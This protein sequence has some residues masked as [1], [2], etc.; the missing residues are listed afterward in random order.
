MTTEISTIQERDAEL[1]NT[2][3]DPAKI[4]IIKSMFAKNCTNDEFAV[5]LELARRYQLDPFSKQIWA[6]KYNG[7]AAQIFT[8]RDGFLSIAHRSGVFDGMESGVDVD[9]TGETIGWAKVYRK[10]MTH[11]FSITVSLKEYDTGKSLWR[12]KPRTMIQKV[13]ESQCLRRAFSISGLYDQ[14]E[15]DTPEQQQ[16]QPADYRIIDAPET[17]YTP[18]APS[19]SAPQPAATDQ[20]PAATTA[21][22]ADSAKNACVYCGK[23]PLTGERLEQYIDSFKKHLDFDLPTPICEEC[24]DKLWRDRINP[25]PLEEPAK[26]QKPQQTPQPASEK[27]RCKCGNEAM[28]GYL[29]TKYVRKFRDI[30]GMELPMP[31]CEECA[32]ALWAKLLTEQN[33]TNT[34][35]TPAGI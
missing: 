24:A 31:L 14:D 26:D 8:G 20:K 34:A 30:L 3:C 17:H 2:L 12:E 33:E 22:A 28:E 7:N 25:K 10:D 35:Q 13:A 11:P 5:F 9:K 21:P 18:R 16:P 23:A 4:E 29:L 15:I 19:A 6:I 27:P 32:A 1:M